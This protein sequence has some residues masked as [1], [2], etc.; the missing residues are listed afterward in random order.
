MNRRALWLFAWLLC[1][2]CTRPLEKLPEPRMIAQYQTAERI[3]FARG[4]IAWLAATGVSALLLRR[5]FLQGA[6]LQRARQAGLTIALIAAPIYAV[7][8]ILRTAP[9]DRLSLI[10]AAALSTVVAGVAGYAAAYWHLTP[11]QPHP[12]VS[13]EMKP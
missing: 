3:S 5:W 12:G 9:P 4:T 11:T 2:L 13:G 8:L 10:P 7:D 6:D 1:V